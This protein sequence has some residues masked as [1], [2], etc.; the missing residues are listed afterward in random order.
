MG[1]AEDM[2]R[3]MEA[4]PELLPHIPELVADLW[5]LGSD[6]QQIVELLRPLGLPPSETSVLDLGCGKGAVSI[7]V[8]REL[9][10][11][12]RGVDLCRPFLDEAE[13]RARE[14]G[15]EH[16]TDFARADMRD[17][18]RQS[19]GFDV[20]LYISVGGL[21]G[22]FGEIVGSLRRAVRPGGHLI[23]DDG[24]LSGGNEP[25]IRR[26]QR[27]AAQAQ[28]HD[29][30]LRIVR[31]GALGRHVHQLV[32]LRVSNEKAAIGAAG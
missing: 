3:A 13:R 19:R 9:G 31:S 24:F 30:E 15:V 7:T 10:F 6:P 27:H 25:P 29:F 18:L 23:V 28:V 14:H 20:A 2:A 5:E 1:E 11:H 32:P 26:L 22:G 17:A 12:A 16:L 21:L 4:P 8:A